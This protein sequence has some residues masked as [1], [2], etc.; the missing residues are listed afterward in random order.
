MGWFNQPAQWH[1]F[2]WF[3]KA[4]SEA[5]LSEMPIDVVICA[6]T[7]HVV[8]RITDLAH[9]I[10]RHVGSQIWS[11][12]GGIGRSWEACGWE[13]LKLDSIGFLWMIW[14]KNTPWN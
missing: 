6:D 10:P 1:Q 9:G 11:S 3:N 7:R 8:I 2:P 12:L 4:K 13:V 5:E 14:T